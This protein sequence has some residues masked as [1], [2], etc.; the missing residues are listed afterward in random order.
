VDSVY[1][2]IFIDLK[3]ANQKCVPFNKQI[4][5]EFG[6]ATKG[7][8][9][10]MLALAY[11]T[12]ANYCYLH[13]K[14]AEAQLN[15]QFAADWA[16]SVLLSN[17]YTLL[18]NYADL[19]DVTKEKAAYQEV[20]YG[21]Q[22]TRDA[23]SSGAGSKGSEWAYY[24]QPTTKWNVC[25]NLTP[26]NYT[27]GGATQ[28]FIPHNGNGLTFLQPWFVYQYFNSTDITNQDYRFD[29]SFLTSWDGFTNYLPLS[30]RPYL[31]FPRKATSASPNNLQIVANTYLDK[32]KDPSGVD[33]RNNE[34]DL[35][36]LRLAEIY[37]I[38]AEALNELGRTTEAYSPFNELR[39]RARK[40]NGT[41]RNYP[42]DLA[43]GLDKENFRLAV[44]N[45]RGLELV[46][47]G[48]RYFDLLRM[49]Y[50]NTNNTFL[51]W[52]F[53]T[54]Y[55]GLP[56]DQ[57]AMPVWNYGPRTWSNGRVSTSSVLV[58]NARYLLY[59]IPSSESDANPNFA[60]PAFGLEKNNPGW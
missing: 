54:F 45:E 57:K 30:A 2:Q 1:K 6:R 43:T 13:N 41:A 34:N 28:S 52:R 24:F 37:L 56:V 31:T 55:P 33:S 36:V 40:A 7:A 16:D 22:F 27:G 17:Q 12:Y 20:I 21:I 59:P 26:V 15:Y 60:N 10:G 32:Y 51:Q 18:S 44:F 19:F 50:P 53:E 11:L 38:K 46:G 3:N 49:R 29:V 14:A 42:A 8:A 4:I 9:Q 23:T 35:F 5:S 58:W 39:K 47:E 48:Q 25:G